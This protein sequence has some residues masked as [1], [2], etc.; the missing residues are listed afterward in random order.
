MEADYESRVQA[1]FEI[2]DAQIKKLEAQA[3]QPSELGK[4]H[5]EE[6]SRLIVKIEALKRGLLEIT[7]EHERAVPIGQHEKEIEMKASNSLLE[8][9]ALDTGTWMFI[10]GVLIMGPVGFLLLVV[11][12][13]SM[14]VENLALGI[15]TGL[16]YASPVILGGIWASLKWTS[17]IR[18]RLARKAGLAPDAE[19]IKVYEKD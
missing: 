5:T 16:L 2:C 10:T 17:V 9:A 13:Y 11:L 6:I 19:P 14:M 8:K 7:D 3:K 4:Q 15:V 18:E 1:Q 12:F